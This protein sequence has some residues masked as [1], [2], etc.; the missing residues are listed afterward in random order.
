MHY[1]AFICVILESLIVLKDLIKYDQKIR[2]KTKKKYCL[3]YN[4]GN[5][6]IQ[7]IES[8]SKNQKN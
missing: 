6:F 3:I 2:S 5:S 4:N 8:S 7:I 1:W